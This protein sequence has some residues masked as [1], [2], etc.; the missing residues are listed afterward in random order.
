M[1]TLPSLCECQYGP[2]L[3]CPEFTLAGGNC[4]GGLVAGVGLEPTSTA[5]E[6]VGLPLSHPTPIP[7]APAGL[8]RC[9]GVV[10]SSNC[11]ECSPSA[12]KGQGG[13]Y[14]PRSG[15]RPIRGRITLPGASCRH[16]ARAWG[17]RPGMQ[18]ETAWGGKTL[19]AGRDRRI[20]TDH[21]SRHCLGWRGRPQIPTP[22]NSRFEHSTPCV[23]EVAYSGKTLEGVRR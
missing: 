22:R 9:T 18:G 1:K 10:Q 4:Q 5:Y 16:C 3:P 15:R 17:W 2:L 7:G 11:P 19:E 14:A 20:R 8:R 21:V 13:A 6:A 23:F 12:A